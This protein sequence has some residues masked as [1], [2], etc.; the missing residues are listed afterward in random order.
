MVEFT[1]GRAPTEE[2]LFAR[3]GRL[4]RVRLNRPRA[5]NALTEDMCLSMGAEL[6]AWASDDSIAAVSIEGA[7]E[8]GLCAGG[9]VVAVRT[10]ALMLDPSAGDFWEAEYALDALI[11]DYP[12]PVIAVQDG[13]VMGGGVG[14]SGY[15]DLRLATE[16]SRIAMPETIIGFF[17]DVGALYLL[18][19]AP[20]ELGTHMALTGAT[21]S[22]AD[23]VA[24]GISDVLVNSADVPEILARVAETGEVDRGVGIT[25]PY[26]ELLAQR[27]WIDECYV[28]NSAQDILERLVAHPAPGAQ[29]AAQAILS[30]SPL[31]VS[32]TL[33]ALRRAQ[34]LPSAVEVLKQDA[35]VAPNFLALDS[36]FTEGVRA[37]LVEK[38]NTPKWR[39]SSLLEVS[40]DEVLDFFVAH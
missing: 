37:R 14:L 35:V 40:R 6:K 15:A 12:K 32:V 31:S 11:H 16:R 39:H 10:L 19:N 18:A 9:D 1:P 3:D 25:A 22:G 23:A 36:D 26:S 34:D 27:S 13:I 5:I 4:G 38:D 7:G 30:R 28:G 20:G 33:E 8:K 21:I 17:P 24:V 29:D 2:V